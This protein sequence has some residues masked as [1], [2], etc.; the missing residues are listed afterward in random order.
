[1]R[2]IADH[3]KAS[4]MILA[5]GITPS[6]T[7]QGYVL[8]RLLRRAI[9][10]F[11]KLGITKT[12]ILDPIAKKVFEIY[13]DYEHIQ[14]NKQKIVG[15]IK[16]EE[17]K[18]EKTLEQGLKLFDKITK[19][20][21]EI[22]GKNAFLLF[23]SYGFPLEMTIE[24]ASEKKIKVDKKGYL[25]HF[26]K[27]QE[28]SRTATKGKFKSGL[29]DDSEA[30][31][32][33]HTATHLLLAAMNSI[34]EKP[35]G[36]SEI[37]QRGSNITAERARFD[38][39]YDRKL[40]DE[41]VKQIEKQVNDWIKQGD[42]I[43]REEMTLEEAKASGAAGIFEDKYKGIDKL[44][45]YTVGDGSYSKEICT[46]PHVKSLKELQDYTFKIKK[47]KSVGAGVRRVKVVLEKI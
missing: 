42:K 9:M 29:S 30:T 24:L 41:E 43:T 11:R 6:N 37:Q 28:L 44:S 10:N 15:E 8:R 12:K 21:S 35:K 27:H 19:D 20:K 33:L 45:I 18:F 17:E 7:E 26:E 47:Q 39:S 23:Q 4:V 16:A 32:R 40:T 5:D 3:I 22:S 38:F 1:M 25:S 13:D 34:L 46:G 31:T 2:I 36:V 14:K